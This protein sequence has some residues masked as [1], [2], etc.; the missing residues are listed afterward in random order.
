MDDVEEKTSIYNSSQKFY[1]KGKKAGGRLLEEKVES[2][3][4]V[5]CFLRWNAC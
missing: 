5:F 1:Y 2:S 3:I 4:F